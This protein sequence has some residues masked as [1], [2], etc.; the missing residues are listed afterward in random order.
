MEVQ[1]FEL[2]SGRQRVRA[3]EFAA[4]FT[5]CCAPALRDEVEF[6]G[7]TIGYDRPR[8]IALLEEVRMT[9]D[10]DEIDRIQAA[11]VPMFQEDLPITMLYPQFWSTVAD[12]RVRG[13]STPYR[14][15]PVRHVEDWWLEDEH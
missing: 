14:A 2:A 7:S 3:G 9:F 11:L 8:F 4:A 15:S 6:F 13:L 10:P 5:L 12:L 1:T